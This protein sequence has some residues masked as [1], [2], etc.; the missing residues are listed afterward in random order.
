VRTVLRETGD[1]EQIRAQVLNE[2]PESSGVVYNRFNRLIHVKTL[3]ESY[4]FA[5][6]EYPSPESKMNKV[7]FVKALSLSGW[8]LTC[9]V[10]FGYT[11]PAAAVLV[12][13]SRSQDKVIVL[14]AEMATGFSNPD[15]LAYVKKSIYD[16][17][18]FDLLCPDTADRSSPGVASK[19]GMAARSKKPQKIETGVSWIRAHLWSPA[20]QDYSLIVLGDK[21]TE[22]MI[23]SFERWQYKRGPMGFLYGEYEE[24]SEY[25][26]GHDSLRYAIDPYIMAGSANYSLHTRYSIPGQVL[27]N[28][29]ASKH[30]T[31]VERELHTVEGFQEAMTDQYNQQ[32]GLRLD[33]SGAKID[34][35]LDNNNETPVRTTGNLVFSFD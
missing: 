34:N 27:T 21:S 22:H 35:R 15:W 18:G 11:D 1:V 20:K 4:K 13:Y 5:F 33:F 24:G 3:E 8:R 7:S 29:E 30:L 2:R 9:G 23:L 19:L 14:H 12:A 25:D 17:F 32:F 26:H 10:D 31:S 28:E 6:G 16:R